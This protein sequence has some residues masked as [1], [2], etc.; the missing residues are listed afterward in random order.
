MGA[1]MG[2]AVCTALAV[3]SGRL[4]ASVLSIKSGTICS[5]GSVKFNLNGP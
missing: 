2:H 5:V 1:I 4:L 3:I